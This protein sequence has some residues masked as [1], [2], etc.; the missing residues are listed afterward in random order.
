MDAHRLA[1]KNNSA[2]SLANLI[3]SAL[4]HDE[5]QGKNDEGIGHYADRELAYAYLKVNNFS[6]ALEH[7]LIE[8]NRRSSNI[9]ANE[10][11]AWAYYRNQGSSK[12]SFV[13][14]ALKTKSENPTL[15][16][17]AGLIYGKTHDLGDGKAIIE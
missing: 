14:A 6:K 9:D 17:R 16:C 7:A 10:T 4:L 1:G 15:L 13:Q 12:V 8:Y 11:V 5:E 3:I 2:D